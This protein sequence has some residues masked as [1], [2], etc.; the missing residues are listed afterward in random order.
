M[1]IRK[2]RDSRSDLAG[3]AVQPAGT[4]DRQGYSAA[5]RA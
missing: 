4:A 5:I 1:V 2:H 3:L